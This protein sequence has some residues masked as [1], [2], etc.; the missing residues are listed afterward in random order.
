M[1]VHAIPV[2]SILEQEQTHEDVREAARIL[3]ARGNH[4]RQQHGGN[5]LELAASTAQPQVSG[6]SCIRLEYPGGD[7]M[8]ALEQE[9][10]PSPLGD[11]HW[12][13][14][15]GEARLLAWAL[16]HEP[17]TDALATLFGGAVV[18]VAFQARTDTK[19]FQLE[20]VFRTGT[21]NEQRGWLGLECAAIRHLG[22]LADWKLDSGRLATIGEIE[23]ITLNLL[24][25]GRP[26]EAV[27][28]ADLVPGDVL[29]IG[30][31]GECDGRLQ[32]DR[33]QARDVFGLPEDWAVRWQQGRWTVIA[34]PLLSSDVDAAR[35]Q[36]LLTGLTLRLAELV[37]LQPGSIAIEQAAL[38]GSPVGILWQGRRF[39]EGE[40]VALGAWLGV[41][42][43]HKEG[44]HGSK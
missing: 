2:G 12:Q 21:E 18:P 35:P 23:A 43:L 36:F 17:L 22:S 16:V 38:I 29:V 28:A 41:R 6:S 33:E 26:L 5:T 40:L 13:D 32:P 31:E 9:R 25:P 24:V 19:Q 3:L 14:Y 8:L 7:L 15:E 34:R 42:I 37:A 44:D 4:L 10:G 27:S 11:L 39:G 20:L 30:T 1:M